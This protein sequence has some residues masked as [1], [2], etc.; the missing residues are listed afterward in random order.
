MPCLHRG[1]QRARA[2]PGHEDDSVE[3][4]GEQALGEIQRSVIVLERNLAHRRRDNRDAAA[5]LD[6]GRDFRRHPALERDDAQSGEAG[7][8]V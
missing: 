7:R 2:D 1:E 8:D 3:L 5:P 4:A 6:H